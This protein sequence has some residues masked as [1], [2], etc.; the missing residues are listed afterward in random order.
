MAVNSGIRYFI[1]K[2]MVACTRGAW[3][4]VMAL[5]DRDYIM[6]YFIHHSDF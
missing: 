4:E 3:S 5:M 6:N 2:V 1:S